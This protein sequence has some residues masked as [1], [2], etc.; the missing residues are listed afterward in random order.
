[1]DWQHSL[2][3]PAFLFPS[4]IRDSSSPLFGRE[5][6][7]GTYSERPLTPICG[8][9]SWWGKA[10]GERPTTIKCDKCHICESRSDDLKLSGTAQLSV[11]LKLL[12]LLGQISISSLSLFWQDLDYLM[13]RRC[14]LSPCRSWGAELLCSLYSHRH[15]RGLFWELESLAR[16]LELIHHYQDSDGERLRMDTGVGKILYLDPTCIGS[17]S[18]GGAGGIS[19]G[20]LVTAEHGISLVLLP[21][22]N[23]AF[24][25][26]KGVLWHI[27]NDAHWTRACPRCWEPLSAVQRMLPAQ[28]DLGRLRGGAGCSEQGKPLRQG[29]VPHPVRMELGEVTTSGLKPTLNCSEGLE[30][31]PLT[32]RSWVHFWCSPTSKAEP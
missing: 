13:P 29:R 14:I 11:I 27:K 8:M 9:G 15:L 26:C 4:E 19:P 5:T 10:A 7:R 3:A 21:H 2:S 32:Q 18:P 23:A 17:F 12:L 31:N 24:N 28:G 25:V 16:C 22:L 1:M 6:L 20:D 30:S